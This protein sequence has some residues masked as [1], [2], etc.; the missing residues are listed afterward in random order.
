[1]KKNKWLI[2]A[3][4]LIAYCVP[5]VFLSINGDATSGTMLFYGI[6][7]AAFSL[8]CWASIKTHNVPILFAGNIISFISSCVCAALFDL[9][10]MSW[11]FKPFTAHSLLLIVSVVALVIQAVVVLI[12]VRKKKSNP[13]E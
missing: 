2:R 9:E 13:A 1:M 6:M 3:I 5:Y 8:L 7:I 11:Y 4:L 10:K 12:C